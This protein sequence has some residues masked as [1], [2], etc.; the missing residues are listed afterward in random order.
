MK[1][2]Q[3]KQQND[4]HVP[5]Q[6]G[7]PGEYIYLVN[8]QTELEKYITKQIDN[9]K[10]GILSIPESDKNSISFDSDTYVLFGISQLSHS[11]V[12]KSDVGVLFDVFVTFFFRDSIPLT[13]FSFLVFTTPY[14]YTSKVGGFPDWLL[15]DAEI[16]TCPICSS[17]MMLITQVFSPFDVVSRARTGVPSILSTSASPAR[18]RYTRSVFVFGC[19]ESSC[20]SAP[21][22]YIAIQQ[23]VPESEGKVI[24][25]GS[26]APLDADQGH[27]DSDSELESDMEN[28]DE[29]IAENTQ[30]VPSNN[31]QHGECDDS[32]DDSVNNTMPRPNDNLDAALNALAARL[33]QE[34]TEND[35]SIGDTAEEFEDNTA[36]TDAAPRDE[37]SAKTP[38]KPVTAGLFDIDM[39][40][41]DDEN[42]QIEE[43]PVRVPPAAV[44]VKKETTA[45]ALKNT[46]TT[47]PKAAGFSFGGFD[48][49]NFSDSE[50]ESK[51]ETDDKPEDSLSS[52]RALLDTR[53]AKLLQ[54]QQKQKDDSEPKLVAKSVPAPVKKTI[55]TK[56]AV[57]KPMGTYI[58]LVLHA[59][60]NINIILFAFFPTHFFILY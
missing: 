28:A 36:T 33:D 14:R 21:G 50:D 59:S 17:S 9:Q 16:P 29:V 47:K 43:M 19:N 3:K 54:K 15:N 24:P 8:E 40:F 1:P 10:V 49:G 22:S 51:L 46:S 41:S 55:I 45:T 31:S 58:L 2:K 32:D 20:K 11:F 60:V 27:Y 34:D 44:T 52:L 5:V 37:E 56:K 25:A 26:T 18:T 35:D 13:A 23:V 30:S 4:Q 42:V 6:L 7:V 48:A 53:D 57:F 39:N 12:L 38:S